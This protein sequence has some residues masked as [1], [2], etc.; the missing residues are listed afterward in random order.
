MLTNIGPS[1]LNEKFVAREESREKLLELRRSLAVKRAEY[2][3]LGKEIVAME[4]QIAKEQQKLV[5]ATNEVSKLLHS[6]L[7]GI[8]PKSSSISP[9]SGTSRAA[10]ENGQT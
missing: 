1:A 8:V 7:A 10:T 6:D 2:D 3:A 9:E 4:K 5:D